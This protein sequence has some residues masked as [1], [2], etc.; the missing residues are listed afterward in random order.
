MLISSI[1]NYIRGCVTVIISGLFPERFINLCT[2]GNIPLWN[3]KRINKT[4]IQAEMSIKNFKKTH[5]VHKK[6]DC[7]LHIVEKHGLPF[8]LYRHRKRKALVIGMVVFFGIIFFLSKFVWIIEVT[9]TENLPGQDIIDCAYHA[10]LKTG[11]LAK[12][13]DSSQ[14]QSHIMYHM[15]EI[16]FVTVNRTGCV[17]RIDVRERAEKREHFDKSTPSNLVATESGVIESTLVQSG[18][19]VVTKGDIVYKGQLLV[20]GATDSVVNG[21]KLSRSDGQI[22]AR[23]WR[24]KTIQL[25]AYST[26]KTPTGNV[27]NKR[28][29]KIFDFSLNL[30]IKNKILFEKYHILSYTKYIPL[31]NDTFVPIGIETTTY[32]EY[33]EIRTKLTEAQAKKQLTD[34]MDMLCKDAEIVNRIITKKDNTMTA[35]YECITDIAAEEEINDGETSGG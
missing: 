34:E 12:D 8:F 4:R 22:K 25:P 9:G 6:S 14:I 13:V 35:V 23:V 26:E 24:E 3:I 21:I 19:A 29:L 15:E 27:I 17:V 5:K 7:K 1:I 33:T 11:I 28:K 31:G 30:F 2:K 18:T 10:G 16:G 32:T 20:S